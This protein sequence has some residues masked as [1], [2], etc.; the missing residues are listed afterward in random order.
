MIFVSIV[1][2]PCRRPFQRGSP[3]QHGILLGGI[4]SS[5]NDLRFHRG[6]SM[7]EANPAVEPRPAGCSVGRD[8]VVHERPGPPAQEVFVAFCSG[9]GWAGW[10]ETLFEIQFH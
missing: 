7:S 3:D 10:L 5:T 2:Q 8:S 1:A 9:G 4:P 6:Q